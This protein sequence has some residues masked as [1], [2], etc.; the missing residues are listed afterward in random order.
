MTEQSRKG[1]RSGL[2][3]NLWNMLSFAA[4][5]FRM[6]FLPLHSSADGEEEDEL[7]AEPVR[8]DSSRSRRLSWWDDDD[9]DDE[10]DEE[11]EQRRARRRCDPSPELEA[12]DPALDEEPASTSPMTEVVPIFRAPEGG[13]SRM[14]RNTLI[15][16]DVSDTSPSA[17]EADDIASPAEPLI[18]NPHDSAESSPA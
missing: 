5:Q 10:E 8:T 7:T 9:N 16:D 13:E 3:S 4:H 18:Q 11:L 2:I 12:E 15:E 14:A 6:W 17:P 1:K